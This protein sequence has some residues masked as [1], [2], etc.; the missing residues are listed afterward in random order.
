MEVTRAEL[1]NS[2]WSEPLGNVASRYGLTGNG[3][4]KICDRL[5]IPRPPRSHWTRSVEARDA[6][7]P[8]PP[9]PLGLSETF[10]LGSR[11]PRQSPGTRTRMSAEARRQ[12][13]LDAAGEIAVR[14][15]ISAVTMRS[16]ASSVG[17]SETQ[18]HNCFGGRTDLLAALARREIDAQESHRR[19]NISRGSSHHTRVMLSTIGYLHEAH[20][21]GPLMQM[22]LHLPEVREALKHERASKGEAAREPILKQL[23][24]S[25]SMDL[26][27]AKAATAALTAVSVKAGGIVASRRAPFATVEA[28]CLHIVMAGTESDERI[29]SGKAG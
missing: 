20:R 9:A 26:A 17:I 4:A 2:V 15:G 24:A 11:Q 25:G 13:L 23:V 8:L 27:S 22:L 3:L 1:F 5:A 12:Q 19:R 6:Q 16:V 28:I 14:N 21:R 18:V 7:P 29:A 10:A